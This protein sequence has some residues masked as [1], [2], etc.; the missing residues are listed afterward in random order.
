MQDFLIDC[1]VIILPS[2]STTVLLTDIFF[3]QFYIN[4]CWHAPVCS[5]I[6]VHLHFGGINCVYIQGQR[7]NQ[8]CN[9]QQ[10]D[11][12]KTVFWIPYLHVI[13]KCCCRW[14]LKRHHGFSLEKHR[15]E[16]EKKKQQ[17]TLSQCNHC[18]VATHH[19]GQVY[20]RCLAWVSDQL[21]I[22][23]DHVQFKNWKRDMQNVDQR[24]W[25]EE[26]T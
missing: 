20:N 15:L 1:T 16:V 24:T 5:L 6:V 7:E 17:W 26:S 19:L 9:E 13:P 8:A 25:R 2:S 23:N 4:Y 10:T 21:L 18:F 12:K 3:D 11:R 22:Y 14:L